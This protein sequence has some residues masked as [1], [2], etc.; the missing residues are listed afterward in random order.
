MNSLIKNKKNL[1]LD[2][3]IELFLADS[4]SGVTMAD[5]ARNAGVAEA[6]LYRHFQKKQN[7]VMQASSRLA[8]KVLKEYSLNAGEKSGY[9][10][11]SMFYSTYLDLFKAHPDY[12]KFI[13][14]LD[15]Y[16]MSENDVQKSEYESE[17]NVF[18]IIFDNAYFKGQEDG[19]VKALENKDAFYFSTAHSLL[20]LCKFL[21]SAAVLKQDESINKEQEIQ[22]LIDVFLQFVKKN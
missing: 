1:I 8:E 9:E 7:I 6:T 19:T 18:K 20:N 2:K 4:I 3:T 17:V 13:G 14:E 15:A 21:A 22:T 11:I 10:Q 5:I 12:F 16:L